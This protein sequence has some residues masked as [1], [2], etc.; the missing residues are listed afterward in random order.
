MPSAA[1]GPHIENFSRKVLLLGKQQA[2]R[3]KLFL[4]LALNKVE[5]DL[6]AG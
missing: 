5:L 6:T 1:Y 3:K 2:S 4:L